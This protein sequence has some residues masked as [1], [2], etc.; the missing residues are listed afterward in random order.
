MAGT[1]SNLL[2]HLVFSPKGREPLIRP[3]F[4]EGLYEYL[5]G[6]VRGEKGTTIE[7]GGMPDHL[8]LLVALKTELSLAEFTKILKA[9]SSKWVNEQRLLKDRFSWQVGYGAF[10]VSHS[11]RDKVQHYIRNQ[12]EHHRVVTFQEE[13]LQFLH[14]HRIEYDPQRIWE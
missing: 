10:T 13:F 5:G 1:Y 14:K 2:Y 11:Q 4:R 8:H 9:K 6:I 7:I 12:A 3:E